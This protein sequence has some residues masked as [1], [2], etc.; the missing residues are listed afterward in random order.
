MTNVKTIP[1]VKDSEGRAR[2]V[3]N[4]VQIPNPSADLLRR[5]VLF[6][7]TN[8]YDVVLSAAI[9]TNRRVAKGTR[10]DDPWAYTVSTVNKNA[11][12]CAYLYLLF[13]WAEMGIRANLDQALADAHGADWH[14]RSVYLDPAVIQGLPYDTS[15][16]AVKWRFPLGQD[17]VPDYES[18]E[19]FLSRVTFGLLA[20][21]VI[22]GAQSA[23]GSSQPRLGPVLFA[24]DGARLP[25]DAVD[26]YLI[27]LN[28]RVRRPIAH[29]RPPRYNK[30]GNLFLEHESFDGSAAYLEKVLKALRFDVAK[31]LTKTVYSQ[32]EVFNEG[33]VRNGGRDLTTVARG[34][35]A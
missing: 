13:Q 7:N 34:K 5:T 2:R 18:P 23:P 8:G 28:T 4:A 33:I 22:Y 3:L 24:P 16:D 10:I 19:D 17:P 31:A 30:R 25:P 1:R 20:R 27:F 6:V 15:Q 14:L 26:S 29:N 32:V 35:E 21:M 11:A 12:R 9:H